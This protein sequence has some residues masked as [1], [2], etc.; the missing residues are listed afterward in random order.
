M[1]SGIIKGPV[2]RAI[3]RWGHLVE[4]RGKPNN[5]SRILRLAFL[6]SGVAGGGYTA[7]SLRRG[8]ATWASRNQW[9]SKAL[10]EYVGWRD[11]HW[12]A[13]YI[14]VDVTLGDWTR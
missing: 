1:V 6:R 13:R 9:S 4:E 14:E 12:A 5:E 8:F 11:V 3:D 10:M 2:F 7:H